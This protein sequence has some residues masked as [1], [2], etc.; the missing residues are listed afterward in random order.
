MTRDEAKGSVEIQIVYFCDDPETESNVNEV[1]DKI[2]DE[3][4]DYKKLYEDTFEQLRSDTVQV[5]K[6]KQIARDSYKIREKS[7][8]ELSKIRRQLFYKSELLDEMTLAQSPDE[9]EMVEIRK[10]LSDNNRKIEDMKYALSRV[11][12]HADIFIDHEDK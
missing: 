11:K 1:I 12:F 2:Y 10:Q 8:V 5:E 7:S 4:K 6:Y 3:N 9:K